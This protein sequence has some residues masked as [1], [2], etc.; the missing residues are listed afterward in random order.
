MPLAES[1]RPTDLKPL[2]LCSEEDPE[3]SCSEQ[4]FLLED[5]GTTTRHRHRR[6]RFASATITLALLGLALAYLLSDHNSTGEEKVA[7]T[8]A[9]IQEME[10]KTELQKMLEILGE[11]SQVVGEGW[12]KTEG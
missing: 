10:S 12:N 4:Q 6:F 8:R 2:T 3:G 1:L 9:T 5:I 11:V 7:N